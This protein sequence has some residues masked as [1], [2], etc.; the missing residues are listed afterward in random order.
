MNEFIGFLAVVIII[1]NFLALLFVKDHMHHDLVLLW[2]A[3]LN[4]IAFIAGVMILSIKLYEMR[5]LL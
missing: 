4:S 2:C 1:V 3:R 5:S